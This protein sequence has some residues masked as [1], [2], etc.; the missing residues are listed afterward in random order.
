MK[1]ST[2]WII[3]IIAVVFLGVCILLSG[4][5]YTTVNYGGI[6]YK[7]NRFTGESEFIVGSTSARAFA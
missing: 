3:G 6:L 5:I 7:T 2:Q 4:G 1:A